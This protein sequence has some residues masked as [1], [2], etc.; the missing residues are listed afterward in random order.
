MLL[1]FIFRAL[2]LLPL[3][4]L[5]AMGQITGWVIYCVN[6]QFRHTLRHNLRVAGLDQYHRQVVGELGKSMFELPFIWYASPRRIVKKI[7]IDNA[8]LYNAYLNNKKNNQGTIFLTPHM[9]CFEVCA[10]IVGSKI[11][12]T[13]LYRVPRKTWLHSF[14]YHVRAREY[15]YPVPATLSGVRKALKALKK[16]EAVGIL[17]DQVP[18][19]GEGVW[20]PFFNQPAYTMVLPATLH[21]STGAPIVFIYA[22][23]LSFGRGFLVNFLPC[24]LQSGEKVDAMRQINQILEHIIRT[25]PT[26]YFWSYNRYKSPG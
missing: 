19:A 13:V 12:I 22:T 20:V 17:P 2:S 5:H 10:H 15:I 7:Y 6:P 18:Q 14:I 3:W 9:G 26:Q 4:L 8:S 11:P 23:R 16:G 1:V 21:N 24:Q 25:Y